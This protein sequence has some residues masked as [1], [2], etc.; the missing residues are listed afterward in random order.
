MAIFS[1]KTWRAREMN[2]PTMTGAARSRRPGKLIKLR[3]GYTHYQLD[4]DTD[5]P[6]LICAHGWSTSSYVWDQLKPLL[7]ERGYRLLTYDL[8]GRGFSDRP[9]T[10]QTP[11]FFTQQLTE[12]LS[13]LNLS[14]Q[15][16][17]ILGYSMGGAIAAHFVSQNVDA[18]D[19]ML[20]VAPAGMIVRFPITRRVAHSFPKVFDPHLLAV[21][22]KVLPSQFDNEAQ[23][24]AHLPEVA[25]V[26]QSQKRELVYRGYIPSLV[27]SLNGVL[28]SNMKAEHR[29]IVRSELRI[30][31]VFGADDSTIPSPWAK[32]L[33][34]HW[35]PTGTSVEI[36]GAGH[37]LTYTHFHE[38]MNEL[39]EVLLQ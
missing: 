14:N 25:R 32:R 36:R 34:D 39:D 5:L 26:V 9:D 19:R 11:G 33:F 30:R 31:A 28:A 12:L 27:S 4:E 6:I 8:Y 23:G 10:L 13:R 3:H 37:G 38:V 29:K 1:R 35:Y 20:L 15:R 16:L 24:F 7:R 21:L 22:P 17:N 2:L 18:V